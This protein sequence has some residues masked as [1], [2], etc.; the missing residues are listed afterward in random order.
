MFDAFSYDME[1]SLFVGARADNH[2]VHVGKRA[3]GMHVCLSIRW[4]LVGPIEALVKG[5]PGIMPGI[6]Q[7]S[8]ICPKI[9]LCEAVCG[10][11]RDDDLEMTFTFS[12]Y[13]QRCLK[14]YPKSPQGH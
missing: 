3:T 8:R 5:T 9:G 2:R 1:V 13:F 11:L 12:R 4:A 7:A 14:A 10:I 6:F